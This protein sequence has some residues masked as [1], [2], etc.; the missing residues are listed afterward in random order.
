MTYLILENLSL[1]ELFKKWLDLNVLMQYIYDDDN[2]NQLHSSN[3]SLLI[4][5]VKYARRNIW[6]DSAKNRCGHV[7]AASMLNS[8][9]ALS[10]SHGSAQTHH[11][12]RSTA[13][14]IFLP[15]PGIPFSRSLSYTLCTESTASA[16]TYYTFYLAAT[17]QL[18]KGARARYI[19]IFARGVQQT[20]CTNM[21]ARKQHGR[22]R[23]VRAAVCVL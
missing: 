2:S 16:R 1:D 12:K 17:V 22:R 13:F 4:Q 7:G 23:A 6:C 10:I 15:L 3:L 21:A 19:Y 5:C 18:K 11:T 9:R 14:Y 20:R 8:Q